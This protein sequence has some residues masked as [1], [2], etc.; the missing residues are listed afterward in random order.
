MNQS[1]NKRER[2]YIE[3]IKN[4]PCSVCGSPSPSEAHH[5]DQKCAWLCIPLC[6]E[7]HRGN[8]GLHGTKALWRVYKLDEL[9]A[10][11][12]TIEMMNR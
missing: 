10:L 6:V 4:L 11:G 8:E 2:T 3:R 1:Y 12:K 5:I 9:G 7:C